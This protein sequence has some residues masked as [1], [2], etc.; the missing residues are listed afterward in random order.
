MHMN[1]VE[2]QRPVRRELASDS[3]VYLLGIRIHTQTSPPIAH[4]AG[5]IGP[6]PSGDRDVH[7]AFNPSG[8]CWHCD[9]ARRIGGEAAHICGSQGD[10]YDR[11]GPEVRFAVDQ[12]RLYGRVEE[13]KARPH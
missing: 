8:T 12:G 5:E 10:L 13:P 7:L 3:E 2:A 1:V 4:A 9:K 11:S 6:E